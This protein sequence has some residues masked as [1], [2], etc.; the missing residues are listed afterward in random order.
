M[1]LVNVSISEIKTIIEILCAM[2]EVV[3]GGEGS[4]FKWSLMDILL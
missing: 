1:P 3:G 2:V 4:I